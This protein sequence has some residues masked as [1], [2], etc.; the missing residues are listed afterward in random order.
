LIDIKHLGFL[1]FLGF[2]FLS[3]RKSD[4]NV[5]SCYSTEDRDECPWQQGVDRSEHLAV[6]LQCGTDEDVQVCNTYTL[7][8]ILHETVCVMMFFLDK[9]SMGKDNTQLFII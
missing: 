2:L 6:L 7:T 9:E 8:C 1:S 5:Y 3:V 4:F